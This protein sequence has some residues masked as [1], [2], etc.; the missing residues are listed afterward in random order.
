[1]KKI[2]LRPRPSLLLLLLS[3][4]M[5]ASG[6]GMAGQAVKPSACPKPAPPPQN[7]MRQPSAEKSLR[8]EL[9]ESDETPTTS[10]VPAKP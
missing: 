10:S 9:F 4:V 3:C 6:C 1:M 8:A 7:V 5:A 2:E